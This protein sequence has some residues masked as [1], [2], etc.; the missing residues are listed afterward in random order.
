MMVGLP[1]AI[2]TCVNKKN[3]IIITHNFCVSLYKIDYDF[4]DGL[5]WATYYENIRKKK[6]KKKPMTMI[7]K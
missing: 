2:H 1:R 5:I 4:L 3:K 6:K 7:K